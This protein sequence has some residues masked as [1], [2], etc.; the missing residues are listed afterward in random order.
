MEDGPAFGDKRNL[1]SQPLPSLYPLWSGSEASLLTLF[2]SANWYLVTCEI[3]ETPPTKGDK[4]LL[5]IDREPEVQRG[6]RFG[7]LGMH[8]AEGKAQ[9]LENMV[10]ETRAPEEKAKAGSGEWIRRGVGDFQDK[11]AARKALA[12]PRAGILWLTSF[13]AAAD[14][15]GAGTVAEEQYLSAH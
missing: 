4:A 7:P 12:F 3:F 10:S 1:A 15:W 11:R 6:E 9:T 13:M 5:F 14:R 8:N 2:D